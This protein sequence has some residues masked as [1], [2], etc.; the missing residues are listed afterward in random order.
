MV[1]T[2][3]PKT[4]TLWLRRLSAHVD[5]RR[6]EWSIA[7]FFGRGDA[8]RAD[9]E[10]LGIRTHSLGIDSELD[11]RAVP[12]ARRLIRAVRPHIVHTH[13]LRADLYG[14][15]AARLSGVPVVLSTAYAIGA[16]RRDRIRRL[17]GLLDQ[18]ARRTPMHVL[19]V[20]D[21]V[22]ADLSRRMRWPRDRVH[23]VRTGVDLP[24]MP[25]APKS[26]G[27]WRALWNIPPEAPLVLT[28]ARLSY[29]KDLATLL[30]AA[31][32]LGPSSPARFVIVGDGPMRGDLERAIQARGLAPRVVLAGF[33]RDVADAL[34][35]A[36]L[37]VLPS[38]MEGMPNA[39]LEAMAAGLPAV[40]TN[41]GG[42]PEVVRDGIE[43]LL[44]RARDHRALAHAVGVLLADSPRRKA[45]GA[46]AR[47]RIAQEFRVDLVAGHYAALYEALL[48][49]A[50]VTRTFVANRNGTPPAPVNP[51]PADIP[52]PVDF[53]GF[54]LRPVT[55]DALIEA[56]VARAVSRVRTTAC[57]LNAH[58]FNAAQT[59]RSLSEALRTCDLLYADG[60]SVVW[61]SRLLGPG[62]PE[63]LSS[64]DYFE[65]FCQRCAAAGVSLFLLGGTTGTA[66]RAA[67]AL[68]RL[69]PGL[70][71]AG[72]A[73]GF[74]RPHDE[75]GLIE[76][77]NG[78]GARI[79][80]VGMGSPRQE[81]FLARNTETLE[82]PV[83]W[84]VGA[85]FDYFAGIEPRAPQ[86]LTRHGLEWAY[87]L[88]ADPGRKWRRYVLG[89]PRFICR[90]AGH[91][92]GQKQARKSS[93]AAGAP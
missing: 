26:R 30:Q 28:V 69:I 31:E 73:D 50:C 75:A 67:D 1:S 78:S 79:L 91:W 37:F 22:A 47:L 41:V 35:A 38:L 84:S 62:V 8:M 4:D 65:R 40:A 60:M 93:V 70:A 42:I 74:F 90:V 45:M 71:V 64:A 15:L 54:P 76:R 21:A 27:E 89:N 36:D 23:V 46:A 55:E 10:E 3:E 68:G 34:Q 77:I 87:R 19:A 82:T 92:L 14:G 57:Y 66:R 80:V 85:L 52:A 32:L 88:L 72:T 63:R 25:V 13:L 24:E 6:F 43:G 20:S 33:R 2:L 48:A 53:C 83:R 17:D 11:V 18:F 59:N 86:W 51:G 61:A 58:T 81:V 44:V 39:L 29:E 49:D 9:F 16:Y 56:L 12:A 7:S 5:Y